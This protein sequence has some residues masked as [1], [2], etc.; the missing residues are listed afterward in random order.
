VNA[1]RSVPFRTNVRVEFPAVREPFV[2]PQLLNCGG[3]SVLNERPGT[4]RVQ[5]SPMT[6]PVVSANVNEMAVLAEV[7]GVAILRWE[8]VKAGCL[9]ALDVET[10]VAVMLSI[11]ASVNAAVRSAQLACC[12]VELVVIPL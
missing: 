1:P 7:I 4:C 9:M 12:S 6:I 5:L 10:D 3:G 2:I 11:V 8:I